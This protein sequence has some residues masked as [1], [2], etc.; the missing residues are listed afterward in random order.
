MKQRKPSQSD[1]KVWSFSSGVVPGRAFHVCWSAN[2]RNAQ[3]SRECHKT[4]CIQAL[5]P[6]CRSLVRHAIP[7]KKFAWRDKGS[8]AVRGDKLRSTIGGGF[9]VADWSVRQLFYNIQ[10]SWT[11]RLVWQHLLQTSCCAFYNPRINPSYI[12]SGTL[13]PS[14]SSTSSILLCSGTFFFLMKRASTSCLYLNENKRT[15]ENFRAVCLVVRLL[16]CTCI[17][18]CRNQLIATKRVEQRC[19][20]PLASLA[21]K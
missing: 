5:T 14:Y 20:A 18:S 6:M 19:C 9:V 4:G 3:K 12:K 2:W 11:V 13:P 21:A 16:A 1:I 15:R 7:P 10:T 17:R 8:G